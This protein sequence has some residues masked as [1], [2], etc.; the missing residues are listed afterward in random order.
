VGIAFFDLDRTILAVNSA[1]LWIRR[2]M[3]EGN[4]GRLQ[5]ARAAWWMA[6]YHMGIADIEDAI[7]SAIASLEDELEE[8]IAA[9][10]LRFWDEEVLATIRPAAREAVT[11]HRDKGEQVVL[12]TSSS[13]YL[14]RPAT[15]EL[16][17]DAY[18]CNSFEV[19]DGR[20]TGKANRPLCFGPGK[21]V[22]LEACSFYTDSFSDLPFLERVGKP[23]I[24]DPD[25][26][27]KRHARN[28]GWPVA[29]W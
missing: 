29:D 16:G 13:P 14:S 3:R 11:A 19:V 20:F 24:V 25:P 4:I 28:M 27:L 8:E 26:R 18:L 10:T 2:E 12:L 21:V 5:A 9:R 6:K 17:L 15:E 7:E 23:V 1:T 22:E